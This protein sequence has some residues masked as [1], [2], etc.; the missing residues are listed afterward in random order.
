[1]LNLANLQNFIRQAQTQPEN[2]IREYCEH[3]FLAFL[4]QLPGSDKLLF[5]GGTALRIVFRSPRYSEDLDFTGSNIN[6]LQIE[7]LFTDTLAN[8]EK[9]GIRVELQEGKP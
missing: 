7:D 5:K 4:Y 9:S 3:L 1:M 8:I 2:V 6:Q